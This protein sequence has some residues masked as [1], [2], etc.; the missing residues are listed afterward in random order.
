MHALVRLPCPGEAEM[1]MRLGCGLLCLLLAGCTW[2]YRPDC[3]FG[4]ASTNCAQ[5][6][7]GY[8]QAQDAQAQA[9]AIA[10]NDDAKC[11]SYGAEPGSPSYVQCRMNL[12]NQRAALAIQTNGIATQALIG[13]MGTNPTAIPMPR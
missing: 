11:R 4:F 6:T 10:A 7:P 5:G 2:P 9:A 3:L 12:D 13:R 8:Q 1:R